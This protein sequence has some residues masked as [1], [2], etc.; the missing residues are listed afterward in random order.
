MLSDTDYAISGAAD[1]LV[2]VWQGDPSADRVNV[3]GNQLR[4]WAKC[5][6]GRVYL[7]N[8]ITST[9]GMPSASARAA[10]QTQFESMRGQLL[11]CAI[12]LEKTG[13]EGTLARAVLT[14]LITVT[15]QP[16]PMRVFSLRRDALFWLA[17][18]GCT[19]KASALTGVADT[20]CQRLLSPRSSLPSR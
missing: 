5:N 7:Y 10:L 15:Q 2:A 17:R 19:A 20:L 8:V 4:A 14:T 9:T 12:V 18:Q 1:T 16:F 6:A 11:G 13:V 3:L